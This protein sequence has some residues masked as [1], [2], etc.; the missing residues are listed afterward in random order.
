MSTFKVGEVVIYVRPG[1][2]YYGREVEVL[3][4][5]KFF[6]GGGIDHVTRGKTP[7]GYKHKI[8]N[9]I[10]VP[11]DFVA[12]PD[13]LRKKHTSRDID[14]LTSWDEFHKATGW[15]PMVVA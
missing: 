7:P 14:Q 5:L 12:R 15:S 13:W 9:I 3:S 8:T 1:S 2:P 10:G 6:V 11:W 4:E